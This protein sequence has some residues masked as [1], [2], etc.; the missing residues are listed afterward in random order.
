MCVRKSSIQSQAPREERF[1]SL[2]FP[3]G[4]HL[5]KVVHL[6][7]NSRVTSHFLFHPVSGPGV[8]GDLVGPE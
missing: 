4:I 3:L 1:I 2:P 8:S 6:E 5:C 7:E